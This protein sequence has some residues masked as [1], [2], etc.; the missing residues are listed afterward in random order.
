MSPMAK[1]S[2][3]PG[4]VR[5]GSTAMRPARSTS[6]PLASASLAASG[7]AWTPAAQIVVWASIRDLLPSALGHVDAE[8]VDTH[9]PGAH[10]QLDAEALQLLRRLAGEPVAERGQRLLAA[11]EQE[12][13]HRG[14]IERAELALEA[15][16]R[17]LA[18]LPG[19]LD[20]GR[21]GADDDD[22][23]HLLPLGGVV[24]DGSAISKA[25]KIRRRSSRASSIV[26]IPGA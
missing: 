19:Q 9:D 16:D 21:A 5:S 6:A 10:P 4:T 2:G 17:Q 15:A 18:H 13:S 3:C 7:D 25:P 12:H 8:G 23:S 1:T 26:F 14:R 22:V 24:L 11:V 20:P